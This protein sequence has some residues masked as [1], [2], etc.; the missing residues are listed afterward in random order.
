MEP[1]TLKLANIASWTAKEG[2][3]MVSIPALQRGLVWKPKQIELLWD[4]LMRGIPI[5]SFVICEA[6][7]SQR[8]SDDDQAKYHLLDGQQRVNAIQLG[9]DKFSSNEEITNSKKSILW[10]DIAPKTLPKD[11]SRNFL[12]RVTT[13]AHPWGYTEGDNEGILGASTVREWLHDNLEKDTS[14]NHY[15][16]PRPEEMQPIKAAYPIPVSLLLN[17]FENGTINKEKLKTDV[18]LCKGTWVEKIL[19]KLEDPEFDMEDISNGIATALNTT[20]LA[21]Q[22]PSELLSSSCQEANN[23]DRPDITNIEHLFQRLNQQGTR[24]DGE[25]LIYSLI[26]AY[27]PEICGSIDE[28]SKN[29][30]PCS[31]L[32]TLAFRV[33]FTEAKNKLEPS[34][35]VSTIRRLSKDDTKEEM[36][37]AI[38]DFIN[39]KKSTSLE[40]CCSRIDQWLGTEPQASWGLPPVLRSSIAYN[41][42]DLFL[43]LLL[44]AKNII[45][46]LGDECCRMLTG[47]VTYVAWFGKDY[48]ACTEILYSKLKEEISIQK[49][50]EALDA[51]KDFLYPLHTP[52]AIDE[53]IKIPKEFDTWNW[54]YLIARKDG[55]EQRKLQDQWWEFLNRIRSK[56]ELILYAQR[57]FLIERFPEYDPARKDLWESH[58]RPWDYD[59]ILPSAFT[60][61]KKTDNQYMNFCKQ[62]CNTI[63][64]LRAWPFEDNRSDQESTAGRKLKYDDDLLKYDDD[65]MDKSFVS[66]SELPGFDKGRE[67]ISD[68]EA[69]LD[70]AEACKSRIIRMYKE[71]FE[72]LRLNIYVVNDSELET[73]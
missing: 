3:S 64:N 52:K 44:L 4:S 19:E 22:A 12:F 69:A 38:L 49:M 11:S 73:L 39:S 72:Q 17:A 7:D 53:F 68:A 67:V 5:G 62:W 40:S 59:H 43:L 15:V 18:S 13:P 24:L 25:E 65:L 23:D 45:T 21:L 63:G 51:T 37:S 57:N 27:W 10:L 56:R 33:V 61:N 54:W 29:R 32:A 26:K 20:V 71:W 66:K 55:E 47:I 9:F 28:I 31:K 50:C 70:F 35:S 2:E 60:F 6:I 16:R 41:N 42:Q 1:L 48:R 8:K 36:R 14:T 34:P 46:P 30:M 58:N